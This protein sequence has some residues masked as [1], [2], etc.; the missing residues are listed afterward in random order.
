MG[1]ISIRNS[2]A[3]VV[4][5]AQGIGHGVVLS[6]GSEVFADKTDQIAADGLAVVVPADWS[7][8]RP[9]KLASSFLSQWRQNTSALVPVMPFGVD[10]EPAQNFGHGYG[11]GIVY[12]HSD[13]RENTDG[14]EKRRKTW[15][16]QVLRRCSMNLSRSARR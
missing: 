3:H 1:A 16:D 9:E 13:L 6:A 10:V 14:R 2:T 8:H 5:P 15:S 11:F 4:D 12:V 7:P